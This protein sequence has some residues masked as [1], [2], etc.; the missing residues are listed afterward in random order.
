MALDFNQFAAKGNE[1]IKNL[2]RELGH[3]DDTAKAGRILRATLHALRAQLTVEENIQLLAQL[4]MFLKAVY[5]E[6][7]TLRKKEKKAK[8]LEDFFHEIRKIDKQTAQY[9]F[10][11]DEDIDH[12]LAVVFMMLHRHLSLGELEDLKA[13]LPKDLKILLSNTTMI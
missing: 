9:D 5:V 13:V 7:W 12:A 11:N 1:F 6:D 2:A 3:P 4:P 8:H 10:H